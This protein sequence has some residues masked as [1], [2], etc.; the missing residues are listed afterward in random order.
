DDADADVLSRP[1]VA[2]YVR[3]DLGGQRLKV[4]AR[5]RYHPDLEATGSPLSYLGLAH[6][7]EV[8]DHCRG[9]REG[10]AI[11]AGEAV[12]DPSV[13]AP[14][15]RK[16]AAARARAGVGGPDMVAGAVPE[17]GKSPVV[18]GRPDDLPAAADPGHGQQFHDA[19]V[20]EHVV[21]ASL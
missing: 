21:P 20:G 4:G 5:E 15:E 16:G 8:V 2:V 14:Q 7:D 13:D 1:E 18:Q 6:L 19:V 12:R 10:P 9:Q 3:P 11:G 17:Q